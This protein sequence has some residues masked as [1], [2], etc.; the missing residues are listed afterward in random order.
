MGVAVLMNK[1]RIF[2][3]SNVFHAECG[4][5]NFNPSLWKVEAR[6]SEG[7]ALQMHSDLEVSLGHMLRFKQQTNKQRPAQAHGISYWNSYPPKA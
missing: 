5:T 2:Y 7:L 1:V 4:G 6:G 3:S